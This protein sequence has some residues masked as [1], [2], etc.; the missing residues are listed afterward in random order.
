MGNTCCVRSVVVAWG[1]ITSSL[2]LWRKWAILRLDGQILLESQRFIIIK[3]K[4]EKYFNSAI[5]GTK[6]YLDDIEDILE[7]LKEHNLSVEISDDDNIYDS[8]DEI[9]TLRGETPAKIKIHGRPEGDALFEWISL[10]MSRAGSTIYVNHSKNLLLPAHAIEKIFIQS[11]RKP[12]Y[13]VVNAK[14]AKAQIKTSFVVGVVLFLFSS[15]FE[16]LKNASIVMG[17]IA[18]AWCSVYVFSELNP[19]TN[20]DIEL[21]RRHNKGFYKR[22]KDKIIVG[23]LMAIVGASLAL[24]ITFLTKQFQS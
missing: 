20:T 23:V 10:E 18:L 3:K 17:C 4:E 11:K 13:S 9:K 1:L 2:A 15:E 5:P 14:F 16:G 7:I 6:I 24:L 21:K 19:D 22:N 8:I 12:I